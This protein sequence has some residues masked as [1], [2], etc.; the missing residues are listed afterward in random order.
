[1]IRADTLTVCA[2]E[3]KRNRKDISN[4][5][6]FSF[7][8]SKTYL[9]HKKSF[10]LF[11]NDLARVL[12]ITL[13]FC[14]IIST[15]YFGIPQIPRYVIFNQVDILSFIFSILSILG[16]I[17]GIMAYREFTKSADYIR[18]TR[19]LAKE[20]DPL[21]GEYEFKSFNPET[22][23][24]EGGYI[25]IGPF[26]YWDKETKAPLWLDKGKY[27]HLLLAFQTS[28][29]EILLQVI[30][31][32]TL[33]FFDKNRQNVAI[34]SRELT[35]TES[36]NNKN[37]HYIY[38]ISIPQWL[39][40]STERARLK[41]MGTVSDKDMNLKIS[42]LQYYLVNATDEVI[43]RELPRIKYPWS[44][45]TL[46][47]YLNKSLPIRIIYKEILSN[48]PTS[49]KKLLDYTNSNLP[50]I[51][52]DELFNSILYLAFSKGINQKNI[53]KLKLL[54]QFLK[55]SYEK[56][57]LGEGSSDYHNLHHSLEVVYMAL[58]MIPK[59]IYNIS[60]SSK[61][62]ELVLVAG[63]LHDYDPEQ[64]DVINSEPKYPKV[65]RTITY[66]RKM[67]IH[68]AYFLLDTDD[69]YNFFTGYKSPFSVVEFDAANPQLIESK[70][71]PIES[72]IA[73]TLILRTD[74]PFI[75][76]KEEANQ[77]YQLLQDIGN[78][79]QNPHKI[80]I[81]AEILALADLSV[82]YITS[83]PIRAW[84]R[85]TNLYEQLYLPKFEAVVRTNAFFS[86]FSN[87]PLFKEIMN[88]KQFPDVFKQRWNNVFQFFH[89]GNPAT[90]LNKVISR[91]KVLF[92]KINI[93][94]FMKSV[95]AMESI[96]ITNP[97]DFFIGITNDQNIVFEAK[98]RFANLEPTNASAFWGDVIKLIPNLYDDS[99][100]NFLIILRQKH[101]Y[102]FSD[103]LYSF[104]FS[105][106]YLKLRDNGTVQ[107]MTDLERGSKEHT[108]LMNLIYKSGFKLNP[109][110]YATYFN[111]TINDAESKIN[112][113]NIYTFSKVF[114]R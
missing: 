89:E 64:Y 50:N 10:S 40:M 61:D 68:D 98:N 113:A 67:R 70:D 104:I 57:G 58:T 110:S 52:N 88:S 59:Q 92:S 15:G 76:E 24:Y 41:E 87:A 107:I 94:L 51:K 39:V 93:E 96:A 83:D 11:Y 54:L 33:G 3:K 1:M 27:W 77:F 2:L 36:N 74:F 101:Y 72:I 45:T 6:N 106:L 28:N 9:S 26:D 22:K 35:K 21:I 62:C 99:I 90:Q 63:L 66:I 91:A 31:D 56:I 73:E 108:E 103:E 25:P 20:L 43:E 32:D 79:G 23:N 86:D 8:T 14:S 81:L 60:F 12:F 13:T 53:E 114:S 84:D 38:R 48:L 75:R 34:T 80:E 42:Q 71:K 5:K 37:T 30:P 47:I 82:T 65:S 85:V 17:W 109:E 102:L 97:N 105:S 18:Q 44:I 16:C 69:L 95:D 100:D 78:R 19:E 46:I 29:K 55:R 111:Y 49:R 7:T 112:Q 4:D